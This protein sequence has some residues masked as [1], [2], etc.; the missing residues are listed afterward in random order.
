MD[1][2]FKARLINVGLSVGFV[3]Q[4]YIPSAARKL[5]RSHLKSIRSRLVAVVAYSG[6]ASFILAPWLGSRLGLGSWSYLISLERWK[7]DLGAIAR[8]LLLM[9]ALFNGP[10]IKDW[11]P[12][13]S[14][15]LEG[16]RDYLVGPL[17][18]ELVFRG[19]GIA[20]YEAADALSRG[21]IENSLLFGM[22][23]CH[24]GI[25]AWYHGRLSLNRAIIG[26]LLHIFMTTVFGIVASEILIRTGSVWASFA[27]HS[28]CNWVGPPDF[29]TNDNWY[30]LSLLAGVFCFFA[31]ISYI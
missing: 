22:S 16:I 19:A 21:A 17:S 11:P 13:A 8:A 7:L 5:P 4:V 9:A 20:M 26:T 29:S 1:P 14:H 24:H 3:C 12:V 2:L 10:L 30:R 6:L 28:F 15:G 25:S 18:E 31:F 27:V 23:H